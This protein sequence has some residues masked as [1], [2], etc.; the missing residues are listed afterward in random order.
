M[1][2]EEQVF[3]SLYGGGSGDCMIRHFVVGFQ[4]ITVMFLSL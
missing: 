4:V 3:W 2:E 1:T